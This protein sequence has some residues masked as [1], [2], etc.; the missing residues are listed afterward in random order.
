MRIYMISTEGLEVL[1]ENIA[2][3]LPLYRGEGT[4][5]DLKLVRRSYVDIEGNFDGLDNTGGAKSDA[6]NAKIIFD[7]LKGVSPELA[8]REELWASLTH[9]DLFEYSRTRWKVAAED[10]QKAVNYVKSHFFADAHRLI[11]SRNAVSR[12]FWGGRLASRVK[13]HSMEEVLDTLFSLS[14]FRMNFV[15]RPS[16]IQSPTLFSAVIGQM[17]ASK[18]GDEILVSRDPN[19]EFLKEVNHLFGNLAI[20][21]LSQQKVDSLVA[22]VADEVRERYCVAPAMAS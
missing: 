19:R 22:G 7:A 14:D 16:I 5:K 4:F 21:C 8:R 17:I 9:G 3:N 20:E 1:K 12:L 6:K 11:E 13:N 15:E 10:D 2:V 18:N